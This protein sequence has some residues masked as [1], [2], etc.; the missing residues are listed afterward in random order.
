MM[1]KAPSR[2]VR[3]RLLLVVQVMRAPRNVANVVF[4]HVL[5]HLAPFRPAPDR[6]PSP[7]FTPR[8][9]ITPLHTVVENLLLNPRL[10]AAFLIRHSRLSLPRQKSL[11]HSLLFLLRIPLPLLGRHV[12]ILKYHHVRHQI[13]R[14]HM[15]QPRNLRHLPRLSR[16]QI[17]L[18]HFILHVS[19]V[20]VR[21]FSQH[22]FPH[23]ASQYPSA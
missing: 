17:H 14:L 21:H 23:T 11:P 12:R 18:N 6:A 22:R 16:C 3:I 9:P 7:L 13:N 20:H 2:A 15:N 10:D 4:H 19:H 8:T 1:L 5:P